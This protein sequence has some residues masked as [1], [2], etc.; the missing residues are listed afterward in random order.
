MKNSHWALSKWC[1]L[2]CFKYLNAV[3][4]FKVYFA[5]VG[6]LNGLSD[7]IIKI[8]CVVL[9]VPINICGHPTHLNIN[10]TYSKH[11]VYGSNGFFSVSGKRQFIIFKPNSTV[12]L[13]IYCI[14]CIFLSAFCVSLTPILCV[15][16]F[17][18]QNVGVKSVYFSQFCRFF[19]LL[20]CSHITFLT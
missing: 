4:Q 20:W 2:C 19:L 18:S 8:I 11:S 6:H 9:T 16:H 5:F 3:F 7:F 13:L 17:K 14:L 10:Y 1:L 12:I 15:L